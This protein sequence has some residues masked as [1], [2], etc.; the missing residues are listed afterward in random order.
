MSRV[1]IVTIEGNIGAG[2]STLL[3]ALREHVEH[4]VFVPEPV[5]EWDTVRDKDDVT[6]LHKFYKNPTAYAFP[7]QMMA[8]ISRMVLLRDAV[9]HAKERSIAEKAE[10][11][12]VSER[13]MLTDKNVFALMM[14]DMGHLDDIEFDI[15]NKWFDAFAAEFNVSDAVYLNVSPETCVT[16]VAKRSRPGE[17][18]ISLDYLTQCGNYHANFIRGLVSQGKRVLTLDEDI[19]SQQWINKVM[20]FLL[21]ADIEAPVSPPT[22]RR[23]SRSDA[24]LSIY[25]ANPRCTH[26]PIVSTV[27]LHS[28]ATHII[29]GR[30]SMDIDTGLAFEWNSYAISIDQPTNIHI[31]APVHSVLPNISVV[32]HTYDDRHRG[33]TMMVHVVNSNFEPITIP[34]GTIIARAVIE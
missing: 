1:R 20:Q 4:V 11:L 15:Y 25:R 5:D 24:L 29:P 26:T 33:S 8:F 16:R 18:P 31:R 34:V 9:K 14:R 22:L 13:S 19:S 28:S 10:F 30:G 6:I 7:F 32:P 23:N 27:D 21:P 3:T 17:D 2:K 12:V